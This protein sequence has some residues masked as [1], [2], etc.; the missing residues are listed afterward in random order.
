MSQHTQYVSW[1]TIHM[2]NRIIIINIKTMNTQQQIII[3]VWWYTSEI[4]YK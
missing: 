2:W 1:G 3:K 4:V